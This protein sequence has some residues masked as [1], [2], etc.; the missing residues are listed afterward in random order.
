LLS[1]RFR[2]DLVH[3]SLVLWKEVSWWW[4]KRLVVVAGF[5]GYTFSFQVYPH[6]FCGDICL[7]CFTKNLPCSS[8]PYPTAYLQKKLPWND[9]TCSAWLQQLQT[10]PYSMIWKLILAIVAYHLP[11]W[12]VQHTTQELWQKEM[13]GSLLGDTPRPYGDVTLSFLVP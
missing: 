10:T 3:G 8:L 11:L 13:V 12:H 5:S 2:G 9:P 1:R 7:T 6:M 4:W